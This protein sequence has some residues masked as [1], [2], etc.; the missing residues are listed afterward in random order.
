MPETTQSQEQDQGLRTRITDAAR[1]LFLDHGYSKVSTSEIAE[2][3]GISK[4]TLY[5]EFENKE[6]ILRNCTLPRMKES[7][8]VIDKIIADEAMAFPDKL[9]AVMSA[10]GFQYQR[11][12]PVLMRDVCIHAPTVWK[13]IQDFKMKRFKKFGDLLEEG[14]REGVFRSDIPADIIL[15]TYTAAAENILNPQSLGELPCSAQEAFQSLVKI[16]FDGIINEDS[17][18]SIE[19]ATTKHSNAK[20]SP[21]VLDTKS[22][23]GKAK[24]TGKV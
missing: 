16:L 14:I 12:T 24:R 22:H 9:R 17:R 1:A 4:K 19:V 7:A 5:K 6:E 20:N 23:V 18:A 15:R 13:E 10:I 8:K 2:A 11:A 3:I 21:A